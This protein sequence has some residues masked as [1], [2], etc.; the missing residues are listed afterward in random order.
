LDLSGSLKEDE[1]SLSSTG[2]LNGKVENLRIRRRFRTPNG[3]TKGGQEFEMGLLSGRPAN[4][5]TVTFNKLEKTKERIE[6]TGE[7]QVEPWGLLGRATVRES[8]M[9]VRPNNNKRG[10]KR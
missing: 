10:R 2:A 5:P 1:R 3:G 8:G 4:L 9:R 6:K 7:G